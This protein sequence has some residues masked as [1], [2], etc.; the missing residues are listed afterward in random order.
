M[1]FGSTYISY[2]DSPSETEEAESYSADAI[3]RCGESSPAPQRQITAD[4]KLYA[5][6]QAA[7]A[8][9]ETRVNINTADIDELMT[10]KGI[11]EAKAQ[12][13]IEYRENNG[14]FRSVEEIVNVNGIGEATLEKLFD[15]I[16]V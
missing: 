5:K 9:T 1:E 4:T 2:I 12:A 16:T 6:T 14:K 11:G 10:L 7:L 8:E 15:Y 3:R 13:I